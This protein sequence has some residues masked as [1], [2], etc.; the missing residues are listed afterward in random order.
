MRQEHTTTDLVVLGGDLPALVLALRFLKRGYGVVVFA[1]KIGSGVF[2]LGSG[3][4]S[5]HD[6]Y[7]AY[8]LEQE[9]GFDAAREFLAYRQFV[10]DELEADLE[11]L[12][13]AHSLGRVAGFSAAHD[14]HSMLSLRNRH[15][16]LNRHGALRQLGSGLDF[17]YHS[18][19]AFARLVSCY[20]EDRVCE[21]ETL[22]RALAHE[23]E[24]LG[25]VV[26]EMSDA[27]MVQEDGCVRV[28]AHDMS[29]QAKD[30][31]SFEAPRG[32]ALVWETFVKTEPE[33]FNGESQ[34]TAWYRNAYPMHDF[35]RRREDGSWI[36]GSCRSW[37]TDMASSAYPRDGES[38]LHAHRTPCRTW[39]RAFTLFDEPTLPSTRRKGSVVEILGSG[40]H[41]AVMDLIAADLALSLLL[42]QPC[43]FEHVL[44]TLP[45]AEFRSGIFS[46]MALQSF[47]DAQLTKD[48]RARAA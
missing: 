31:Y 2:G 29:Y 39:R 37:S 13:Q 43:F 16:A 11:M 23:I 1:D 6:G 8:T 14:P 12:G 22:C 32:S 27:V 25:G 4:L 47:L 42:G 21:P 46:R 24:S 3:I 26:H 35:A 10:L 33:P 15:E 45:N 41:D 7:D 44:K 48:A 36:M 9:H 38:L 18:A 40:Q 19:I 30:V 17:G 28:E 20:A 34:Q 5:A